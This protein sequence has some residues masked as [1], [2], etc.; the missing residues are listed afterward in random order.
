[1]KIPELTRTPARIGFALALATLGRLGAASS[2]DV[3]A[4]EAFTHETPAPASVALPPPAAPGVQVALY[5]PATSATARAAA[6]PVVMLLH[7]G[8]WSGSS[9]STLAPH[10]R[11]LAA[12]GFACVNVS[13]RLTSQP[14]VTI[15]EAELDARAAFAW[16]Q[17]EAKSRGWDPTHVN[18]LGESAGG[19]LAC[20]LGVLPPD[21]PRWHAHALV[22]INPVL[23]LTT[24]SWARNQP[25]L[26]GSKPS[27]STPS[28]DPAW[29]FSPTFHLTAAAPPILVLHGR[30]D[31][32]VPVTQAEAFAARAKQVGASVD[33]VTIPGVA[34]AFMLVEYGRPEVMRPAL[35]RIVQ[36]LRTH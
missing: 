30:D 13:Y 35:Q 24:L 10:A 3:A 28:D 11:Y 34:H 25:G 5:S 20:A 33:L 17:A 32:S 19:Q 12:S 7:G 27:S 26:Q 22:L 1:M 23:D 16:I 18:V 9:A 6:V 36:F 29:K 15:A 4:W 14:G 31:T 21:E 2:D 8:G